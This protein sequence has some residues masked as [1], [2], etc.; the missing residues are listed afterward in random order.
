MGGPRADIAALHPVVLSSPV[1]RRAAV[2]PF[3]LYFLFVAATCVVA[4][5]ITAARGQWGGA[6]TV[7][8]LALASLAM[9]IPRLVGVVVL[10]ADGITIVWVVRRRTIPWSEV[11]ELRFDLYRQL[12]ARVVTTRADRFGNPD[13][14][15]LHPLST[16]GR[17][18]RA[19]HVEAVHRFA[20]AAG[21]YVYVD[22]RWW[23]GDSDLVPFVAENGAILRP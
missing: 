14:Y 12:D 15:R 11:R 7:A 5:V 13:S 19:R 22:A 16:L 3:A 20:E 8:F 2:D 10:A 9:A 23:L 1:W 21:T 6:A 17:R 4:V 18:R